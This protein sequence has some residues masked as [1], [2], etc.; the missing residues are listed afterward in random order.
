MGFLIVI[1][2]LA[3]VVWAFLAIPWRRRQ[4]AHAAMQDDVAEG[5]EIIT[6]G[7]IH[8]VV[9]EA[10]ERELRIEIAPGVVVT[11]DRRAVAA[12]AHEITYNETDQM[13]S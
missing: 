3:A 6:A 5:D 8:A 4:R 10:G 13:T 1:V 12:V 11:L 9:K 7:G 2:I